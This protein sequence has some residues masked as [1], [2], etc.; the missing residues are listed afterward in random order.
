MDAGV[1]KNSLAVD[2]TT[3][4]STPGA[5]TS[6]ESLM[7]RTIVYINNVQNMIAT[8]GINFFSSWE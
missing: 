1:T 8:M 6:I 7:V 3:L 5:L 4:G 2:K